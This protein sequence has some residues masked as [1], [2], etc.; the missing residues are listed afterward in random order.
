MRSDAACCIS[1]APART[2]RAAAARF[3]WTA[4]RCRF[5]LH[6]QCASAH[7]GHPVTSSIS[8][9][10]TVQPRARGDNAG[11]GNTLRNMIARLTADVLRQY[12]QYRS[13]NRAEPE[14]SHPGRMG[15]IMHNQNLS[16]TRYTTMTSTQPS[17]N[18]PGDE[19]AAR[20]TPLFK[21]SL[22]EANPPP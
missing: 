3:G 12:R 13:L 16:M 17:T 9:S 18:N 4:W 20:G 5:W 15:I 22:P 8:E 1:N 6:A 11:R 7:K 14:Q 19:G 21:Q 10:D 2:P